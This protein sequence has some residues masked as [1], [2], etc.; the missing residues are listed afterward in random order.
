MVRTSPTE[1]REKTGTPQS[2]SSTRVPA[3]LS[4]NCLNTALASKRAPAAPNSC[5]S[6]FM[7]GTSSQARHYTEGYFNILYLS[8]YIYTTTVPPSYVPPLLY[9]APRLGVPHGVL[10]TLGLSISILHTPSLLLHLFPSPSPPSCPFPSISTLHLEPKRNMYVPSAFTTLPQRRPNQGR[11]ISY[12]SSPIPTF[13]R[14]S[15]LF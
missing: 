13:P 10:W 11:S 9:A 14:L 6:T 12:K 4:L 15:S 2:I 5:L 8:R 1:K 3:Y 7:G